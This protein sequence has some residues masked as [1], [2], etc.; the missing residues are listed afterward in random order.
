MFIMRSNSQQ[1]VQRGY[2]F[3]RVFDR[4]LRGPNLK[5]MHPMQAH[6][7]YLLH[8]NHMRFMQHPSLS[9]AQHIKFSVRMPFD[10]LFWL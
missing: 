7:R 9:S 4:F 2:K 8:W 6:L 1:S 5:A 3:M 10:R